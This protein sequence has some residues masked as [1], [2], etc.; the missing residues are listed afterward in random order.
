M[1]I[2]DQKVELIN[3]QTVEHMMNVRPML[4]LYR[5]AVNSLHIMLN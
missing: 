2:A 5:L 4:S 1:E 3:T